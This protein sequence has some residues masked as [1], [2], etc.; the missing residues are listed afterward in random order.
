MHVLR[1]S[2]AM[3]LL[4][5]GVDRSVIALWLGHESRTTP[6]KSHG[7]AATE[8][9][10][11]NSKHERDRRYEKRDRRREP[12]L[13]VKVPILTNHEHATNPG[14]GWSADLSVFSTRTDSFRLNGLGRGESTI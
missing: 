7:D 6:G 3:D 1:H 14:A 11:V 10:G 2:V 8:N 13:N 9:V 12:K 4:Q 5:Q